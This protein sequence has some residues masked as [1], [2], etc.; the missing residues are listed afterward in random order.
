MT[1]VG[2]YFIISGSRVAIWAVYR[3]KGKGRKAAAGKGWQMPKKVKKPRK[4][5]VF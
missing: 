4:Y 5:C 2:I 1:S 3:A